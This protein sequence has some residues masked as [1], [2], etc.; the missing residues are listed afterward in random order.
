MSLVKR[1]PDS[2]ISFA[3]GNWEPIDRLFDSWISPR[4]GSAA[5]RTRGNGAAVYTPPVEI[6]QEKDEIVL[7]A[8][9]P[10]VKSEDI[11]ITVHETTLTLK[12]SKK[13]ETDEKREGY[14]YSERQYGEFLRTFQ[15][16]ATVE[17]E[18]VRAE[19]KDGILKVHMPL[20]EEA[21]PRKIE[22][23]MQ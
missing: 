5:G 19:F 14:S 23:K 12:G 7:R 11:D 18:K 9:L 2:G 3:L 15:L 22:V 1:F 17:S 13:A 10:G 16:P 6:L 8:E 4:V 21:K 20:A